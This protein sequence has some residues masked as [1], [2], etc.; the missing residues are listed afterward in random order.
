MTPNGLNPTHISEGGTA[1]SSKWGQALA[2]G[3][4]LGPITLLPR[5]NLMYPD[6][7]GESPLPLVTRDSLPLI[8]NSWGG[9]LSVGETKKNE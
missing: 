4:K 5:A 6:R 8:S 2:Q 3:R 7:F 9:P 1:Q